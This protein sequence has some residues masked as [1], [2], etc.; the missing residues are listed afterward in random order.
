M[1]EQLSQSEQPPTKNIEEQLKDVRTV[2]SYGGQASYV[3]LTPDEVKGD[4]P[5]LVAGGWSEGRNALK[6]TGEEL[7]DNG[8]HTVLVD[9][10]RH[11]KPSAESFDSFDK[12]TH[13]KAN[14]LQ[15]VL[16]ATNIDKADVIAHSEG[17]LNAVL[18]ALQNPDKFGS[19]VLVAPAGMIGSDSIFKLAGRFAS[20]VARGATKDVIDNPRI[21]ANL[22]LGVQSYVA[23]NPAKSSS[24]VSALA[25]TTIDDALAYLRHQGVRVGILQSAKDPVFPANRI[26]DHVMLDGPY[27]NVDSYASVANRKAGHDDLLINPERSTLAAVQ[28]LETLRQMG[29][30]EQIGRIAI[31]NQ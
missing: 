1:S 4:L 8:Y 6:G 12:E 25:N 10:A 15:K 2:E 7:F 14:T 30:L 27:Q 3:E 23:K 28:M 13:H 22:S 31:K 26:K 20:K 21:A 17:S 19:L 9:H 11:G 16:E 18:A 29:P 5:V 24:E